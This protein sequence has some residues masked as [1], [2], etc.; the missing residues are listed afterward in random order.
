MSEVSGETSTGPGYLNVCSGCPLRAE[1]EGSQTA[2]REERRVITLS[3]TGIFYKA[4]DQSDCGVSIK[5]ATGPRAAEVAETVNSCSEPDEYVVRSGILGLKQKKV[6][7]C[8]G[9][10]VDTT[11]KRAVAGYI[12][13]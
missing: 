8:R 10:P 4:V 6:S 9:I 11:S 7:N 12:E 5:K 2:Y 1:G 13:R 3:E